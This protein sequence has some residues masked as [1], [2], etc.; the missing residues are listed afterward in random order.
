MRALVRI[1]TVCTGNVCRSPLAEAILRSRLS[2]FDIDISSAGIRALVGDGMT[3][4][5]VELAL[6]HGVTDENAS[7]HRARLLTEEVLQDVDLVLA[8]GREHRRYIVEMMPSRLRSTFTIRELARLA[9]DVTDG[10]LHAEL[11]GETDPRQRL[12]LALAFIASLRHMS[13]PPAD[14]ADDDVLDPYGRSTRTY[15]ISASQLVPAVDG[16]ERI[17]RIALSPTG[18][19][20]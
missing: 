12:R 6:A 1:L 15:E 18:R 2:E 5:T 20:A 13:D 8:M 4:Q 17:I 7:I 3:E 10:E 19:R 9:A 11:E 16:I 14:P